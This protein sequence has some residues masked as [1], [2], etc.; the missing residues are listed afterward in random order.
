MTQHIP[1]RL[2]F[3]LTLSML[4]REERS[5][6]ADAA[7]MVAALPVGTIRGQEHVPV[8][9]FTVVANHYQRRDLWIGWAGSLLMRAAARPIH[10]MVLRELLLRGRPVPG[11]RL[12][13]DAV[14]RTYGFIPVPADLADRAG[15]A[16][17]I[18]RAVH[19]LRQGQ[20]AGFFPEG[21]HGHTAG[22][23]PALPGTPELA[24][25]LSR[26]APLLPA[27]VW[28]EGGRL[29]AAFGPPFH[30]AEPDARALM[31]PLA[32]LLPVRLRGIYGS[33]HAS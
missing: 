2:L 12:A 25:L 16:A 28:E 11:S 18:R 9:A 24:C 3:E 27:A 6:V 29:L 4:R 8:G 15:Q 32:R 13:F 19:L 5:V 22:L 14:A 21:E 1:R 30:L 31:R 23:S 10:W 33:E 17:G 26:W 20:V 7:R